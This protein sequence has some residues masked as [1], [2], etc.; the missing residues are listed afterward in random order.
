MPPMPMPPVM[1]AMPESVVL[2]EAQP[3]LPEPTAKP[4][5]KGKWL[6]RILALLILAAS[7]AVIAHYFDIVDLTEYLPAL[8]E[9]LP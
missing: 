6:K 2:P 7:G 1:P 3:V 9:Y 5:K 8:E 4:K